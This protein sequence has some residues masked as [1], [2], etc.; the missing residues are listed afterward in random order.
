MSYVAAVAYFVSFTL[1]GVAGVFLS[2]GS[3]VS[4]VGMGCLALALFAIVIRRTECY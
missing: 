2:F 3:P 4:A 1:G